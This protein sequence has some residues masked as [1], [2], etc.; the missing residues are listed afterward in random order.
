MHLRADRA[1]LLDHE[2]PPRRGLKRHLELLATEPLKEPAHRR[3]I[4]WCHSCPGDLTRGSVAPLRGDLRPMLIQSHHNRHDIAPHVE[5]DARAAFSPTHRIPWVTGR[6]FVLRM[7]RPRGWYPR[8]F[9][10]CRSTRRA[11]HLR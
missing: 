4:R 7:N 5:L 11:G 3:A 2:P 10:V 1:Q 6:P 8:A 9:N